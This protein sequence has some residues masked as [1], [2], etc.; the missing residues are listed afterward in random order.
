[1]DLLGGAAGFVAEIAAHVGWLILPVMVVWL[2]IRRLDALAVY[3]AAV[4]VGMAVITGAGL[5]LM[6]ILPFTPAPAAEGG[7]LFS[8][9]SLQ[10]AVTSGTLLLVFAQAVPAKGRIWAVA[11]SAASVMVF[12][13]VRVLTGAVAWWPVLGGWL[14]GIGWLGASLWAFQRWQSQSHAGPHRRWRHGLPP[15]EPAALVLAPWGDS[16]LPG[17]R[18]RALELVGIWLL[19]AGAVTGTGFLITGILAPVQHLDQAAVEWLAEHRN[20]TLTALATSIG[21][22]GT[23]PGVIG[24]LLVAAPLAL[25][26]TGRAAPAVFLFVAVIGETALYL[27]T[28]MIVGR[29]RP[30]VDHLSEGLP[31][32]SSFPSGHVAAAVVM[33]GGLALLL[34]AWTPAR[35]RNLGFILAP[36]IVLG[37]ALSRLY[38]GVHYPTDTAVSIIFASVWLSVC[39]RYFRP[40]RGSPHPPHPDLTVRSRDSEVIDHAPEQ[41]K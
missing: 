22:F 32:T 17:G 41:K 20:N 6:T 24:V 15:S 28:G 3:V 40:A 39:W 14:I 35:L 27:M 36:L 10:L 25:A 26:I 19:I 18:S 29:P 5:L 13:L 33:Y 23:T 2:L 7:N 37:I 9:G 38:W 16:P 31:P 8:S 12:E 30:E 11:G 4:A 34:R 1:M 21:S